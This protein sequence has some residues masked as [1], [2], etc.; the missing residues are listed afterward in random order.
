MITKN[1]SKLLISSNFIINKTIIHINH[2]AVIIIKKDREEKKQ[3][4]KKTINTDSK[5]I[6]MIIK[7]RFILKSLQLNNIIKKQEGKMKVKLKRISLKM[8]N[9]LIKKGK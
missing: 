6:M 5:I 7:I 4:K 2:T 1:N 9:T 3:Q 8:M